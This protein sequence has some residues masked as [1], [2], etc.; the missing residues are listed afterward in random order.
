MTQRAIATRHSPIGNQW[1]VYTRNYD[2][3]YRQD[4]IKNRFPDWQ[5]IHRDRF[6][7]WTVPGHPFNNQDEVLYTI[8]LLA[9]VTRFVTKTRRTVPAV[10]RVGSLE[11]L[12]TNYPWTIRAIMLCIYDCPQAG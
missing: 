5:P 10:T 2:Y 4:F 12:M 1:P 6:G 9:E 11:E 8:E 3:F 7:R